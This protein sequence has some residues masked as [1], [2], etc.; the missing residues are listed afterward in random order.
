MAR[1]KREHV[2]Y[3]VRDDMDDTSLEAFIDNAY[4]KT[5]AEQIQ[6]EQEIWAR[7]KASETPER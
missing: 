6:R 1:S 3:S 5:Y 2:L 7:R 4:R